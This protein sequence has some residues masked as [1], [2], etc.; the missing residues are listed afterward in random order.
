MPKS[1]NLLTT[2][3]GSLVE[4]FFPSGWDLRRMDKCAGMSREQLL[5]PGKWWNGDF[6]P[7]VV[8]DVA[9]MDR[10]MGDAI[11]FLDRD[12]ARRRK[13]LLA[14]IDWDPKTEAPT[15]GQHEMVVR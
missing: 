13:K 8:K 6:K 3:R 2:L 9:E 12:V 10:R 7:V 5:K 4:S 1:I 15:K 14:T 11:A